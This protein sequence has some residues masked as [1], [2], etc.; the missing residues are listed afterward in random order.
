MN[1]GIL[2]QVPRRFR[3]LQ[4]SQS[5]VRHVPSGQTE[6]R[7]AR[8]HEPR[9]QLVFPHSEDR[10]ADGTFPDRIDGSR[11]RVGVFSRESDTTPNRSY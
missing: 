5:P 3:A 8:R 1:W 11:R 9:Q 6:L 4:A 7:P 10:L 2:S